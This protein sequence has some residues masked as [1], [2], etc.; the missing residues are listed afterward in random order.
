[1]GHGPDRF[2]R[3]RCLVNGYMEDWS[4][5]QIERA[6]VRGDDVREWVR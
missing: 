2:E 4:L 6:I 3:F 1:M 5:A